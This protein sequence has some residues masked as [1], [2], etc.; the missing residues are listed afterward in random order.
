MIRLMF[1]AT[2]MAI[3][4]PA[5]ADPAP[6]ELPDFSI[7]KSCSLFAGHPRPLALC[8]DVESHYR[9]EVTGSWARTPESEREACVKLAGQSERGKYEVL[10]RCLRTAISEAA[11]KDAV[12]TIKQ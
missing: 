6:M 2:L 8:Q 3:A 7:E 4:A 12:G 9:A 5:L 11:W 10:A 1:F